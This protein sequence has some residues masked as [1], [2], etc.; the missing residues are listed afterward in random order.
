LSNAAHQQTVATVRFL[1]SAT[2]L[3]NVMNHVFRGRRDEPGYEGESEGVGV[4][5]VRN[6]VGLVMR[7]PA[8][9]N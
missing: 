3:S 8:H 6:L 7:I 9:R 1:T 5:K 4:E 2:R